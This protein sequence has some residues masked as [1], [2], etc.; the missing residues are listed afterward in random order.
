MATLL[1]HHFPLDTKEKALGTQ[2]SSL[3]KGQVPIMPAIL[4][5]CRL[6]YSQ[7]IEQRNENYN[8]PLL[9]SGMW[10]KRICCYGKDSVVSFNSLYWLLKNSESKSVHLFTETM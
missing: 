7:D 8:L 4:L 2:N 3:E 1:H 6:M 10:E 5:I 9:P